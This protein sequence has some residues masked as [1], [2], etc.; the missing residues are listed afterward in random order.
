MVKISDNDLKVSHE[1]QER[2]NCLISTNNRKSSKKQDHLS[3]FSLIDSFCFYKND[4]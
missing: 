3:V 2:Q 1:L 4:F